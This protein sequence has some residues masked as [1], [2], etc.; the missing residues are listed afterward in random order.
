M[1]K[2]KYICTDE[3]YFNEAISTNLAFMS[4]PH[5][6]LTST[7]TLD[8]PKYQVNTQV[9]KLYQQGNDCAFRGEH[10]RAIA[11]YTQAIAL[12]SSFV[13]AYCAR[14][15]SSIEIE[16]YIQAETD[17]SLV[18]LWQLRMGDWQKFTMNVATIPQLWLRAIGQSNEIPKI[19]IFI[20]VA[21]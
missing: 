20:T 21:L 19:W 2:V 8:L 3:L 17:S 14:G 18:Q 16:D 6:K 10:E 9:Q 4:H 15:G 12:D 7:P 13:L 1:A 5:V 11:S